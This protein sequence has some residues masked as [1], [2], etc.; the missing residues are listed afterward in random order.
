MIKCFW[1][2]IEKGLGME[3][4]VRFLGGVVYNQLQRHAGRFGRVSGGWFASILLLPAAVL[5]I[6]IFKIQPTPPYGKQTR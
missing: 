2:Y 1:G 3:G 5:H 4:R 6:T